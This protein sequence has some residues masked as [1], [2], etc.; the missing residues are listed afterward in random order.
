MS[1]RGYKDKTI[2]LAL[3]PAMSGKVLVIN[4]RL[5]RGASASSSGTT[6]PPTAKDPFEDL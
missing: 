6:K 2:I 1:K 4:E 3:G 5:Q